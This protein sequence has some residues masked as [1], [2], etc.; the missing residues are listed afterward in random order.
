M[1]KQQDFTLHPTP[2]ALPTHSFHSLA[3][4]RRSGHILP[5]HTASH[6][7]SQKQTSSTYHSTN[8]TQEAEPP[9]EDT[10]QYTGTHC[11]DRCLARVPTQPSRMGNTVCRSPTR[12]W[13]CWDPLNGGYSKMARSDCK[14]AGR[15]KNPSL[16]QHWL[17]SPPDVT[18]S[19]PLPF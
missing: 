8:Q 15:Q 6:A 7:K 1:R 19:L 3:G 14:I 10:Q 4:C 13:R 5:S 12:A 11:C 16:E 18:P 2:P 9:K 17:S